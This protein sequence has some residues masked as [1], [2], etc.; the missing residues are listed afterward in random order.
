MRNINELEISPYVEAK[1][2]WIKCVL[3]FAGLV[4]V[5]F[6]VVVLLKWLFIAWIIISGYLFN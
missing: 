2:S 6:V 1:K 5:V 4:T 3:L